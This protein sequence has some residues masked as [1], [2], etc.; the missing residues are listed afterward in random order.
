M[1]TKNPLLAATITATIMLYGTGLVMMSR[2][3]SDLLWS[4]ASVRA[5]HMPDGLEAP[6]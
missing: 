6:D 1:K 5:S 2:Q 4:T 3:V